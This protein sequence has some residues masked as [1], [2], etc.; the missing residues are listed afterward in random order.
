MYVI[1]QEYWNVGY[2][3]IGQPSHHPFGSFSSWWLQKEAQSLERYK[4]EEREEDDHHYG[5]SWW[6]IAEADR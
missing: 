3:W 1:S 4:E 5:A 6:C 2:T